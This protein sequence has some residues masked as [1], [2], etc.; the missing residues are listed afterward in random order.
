M[1]H[2]HSM[3]NAG[4]GNVTSRRASAG[5]AIRRKVQQNARHAL[6]AAPARAGS[7]RWARSHRWVRPFK[8][9]RK[10]RHPAII[11]LHAAIATAGTCTSLQV[12]QRRR[13]R[14]T[15]RRRGTRRWRAPGPY[16]GAS[17]P[18]A[19]YQR[20]ARGA[21][22]QS[23]DFRRGQAFVE[24]ERRC[25]RAEQQRRQVRITMYDA[26]SC[27]RRVAEQQERDGTS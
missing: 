27:S 21:N 17:R 6:R 22:G 26:G 8:R 24:P 15:A 14:S 4:I 16:R 9:H 3:P 23:A 19:A 25:E 1:P 11:W 20:H 7:P 18:R 13:V 10:Q 12:A 2:P 5:S